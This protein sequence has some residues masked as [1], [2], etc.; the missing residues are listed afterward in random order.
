MSNPVPD[1]VNDENLDNLARPALFDALLAGLPGVIEEGERAYFH[2]LVADD[3][4]RDDGASIESALVLDQLLEVIR[5]ALPHIAAGKVA[6]YGPLRLRY[7]LELG[8]DLAGRVAS[9]DA[10]VVG[11]AGASAAGAAHMA[12]ARGLRRRALRALKNLS[13]LHGEGG[14]R[15]RRAARIGGPGAADARA[16]SLEVIAQELSTLA[17]SVPARVAEDAGATPELL[18]ALRDEARALLDA[19]HQARVA[20]ASVASKYDVMNVLDGRILH[21]MRLLVGALRD[22]RALDPAIPAPRPR[23]LRSG[24]RAARPAPVPAVPPA[25]LSA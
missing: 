20:R 12:G 9:L 14:A 13:G 1:P 17:A 25:P 15:A 23:V 16:R 2:G 10:A 19:R 8:R 24:K 5:P 3:R 22:A 21:E 7:I 6:G 4:A 11:A 18:A